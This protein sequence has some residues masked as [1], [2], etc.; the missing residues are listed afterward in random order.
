M[1]HIC[2]HSLNQH[3]VS[4][5]QSREAKCSVRSG[6]QDSPVAQETV[7]QTS[8]MTS[9]STL[10]FIL[11]RKKDCGYM[12]CRC[13]GS[14]KLGSR[15]ITS[16]REGV[17]RPAASRIF[18]LAFSGVITSLSSFP[19]IPKRYFTMAKTQGQERQLLRC[20]MLAHSFTN[21][22]CRRICCSER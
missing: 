20:T 16:L 19:T 4:E 14:A 9:P 12:R 11:I 1:P 3:L 13:L 18:V 10:V 7:T 8:R 6:R 22:Y 17:A 21:L 5:G 2:S 15:R